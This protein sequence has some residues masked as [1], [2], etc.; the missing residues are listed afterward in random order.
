MPLYEYI[1]SEHGLKVTLVRSMA[2]RDLPV[3]L[4][5]NRV[6]VP[7]SVSVVGFAENT[8]TTK[9]DVLKGYYKEECKGGKWRSRYTKEQIKKAWS[10]PD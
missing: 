2:E 1:N 9:H 3:V 4:Q 10:Q 5:F 6:E 8:N 7:S